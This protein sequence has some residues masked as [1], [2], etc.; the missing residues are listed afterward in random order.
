MAGRVL[1]GYTLVTWVIVNAGTNSRGQELFLRLLPLCAVPFFYVR[2]Q[3]IV[4]A[5]PLF[6]R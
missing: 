2:I 3:E 1:L 4:P 6:L 5:L